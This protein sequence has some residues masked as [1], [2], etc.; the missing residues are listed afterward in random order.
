[1]STTVNDFMRAAQ[2]YRAVKTAEARIAAHQAQIR[3][4]QDSLAEHI[5]IYTD[6]VAAI[7]AGQQMLDA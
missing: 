4:I 7:P 5:S 1:M 2:S 6:F 3:Q